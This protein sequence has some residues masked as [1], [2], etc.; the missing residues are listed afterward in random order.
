MKDEVYYDYVYD[1]ILIQN[2]KEK[3]PSS[4]F[5]DIITYFENKEDYEKCKVLYEFIKDRKEKLW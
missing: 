3:I 5:Y 4:T 2:D 1:L